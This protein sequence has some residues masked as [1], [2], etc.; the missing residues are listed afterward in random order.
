MPVDESDLDWSSIGSDD[1]GFQRKQF[2]AGGVAE[3]LAPEA[4]VVGANGTPIEVGFVD[5]HRS[6][7]GATGG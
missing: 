3:L 2:A 7:R 1:T 5:W 4:G 6:M